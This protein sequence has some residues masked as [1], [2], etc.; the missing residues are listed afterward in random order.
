MVPAWA[1]PSLLSTVAMPA[2]V[3]VI[4]DHL[5]I[6]TLISRS[7]A[8]TGVRTLVA[9][10]VRQAG[11]ILQREVCDVVVLDLAVPGHCDGVM[12]WLRRDPARATMATVRVSA[13]AR[14]G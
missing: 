8:G 5:D 3:L 1:A 12:Q 2:T 9:S 10:D 6:G 13:L 7:L 14:H 4:A 11:L